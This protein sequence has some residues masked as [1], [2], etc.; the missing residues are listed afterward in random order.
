MALRA[1]RRVPL[2]VAIAALTLMLGFASMNAAPASAQ[3]GVGTPPTLP[4]GQCNQVVA[5]TAA[6]ATTAGTLIIG[7]TT[8]MIA[9]GAPISN[10]AAVVVGASI[11]FIP[12]SGNSAGQI[13]GGEVLANTM[14][15]FAVC[16][17]VTDYTSEAALTIGGIQFTLAGAASFT[18]G[19]PTVGQTQQITL[20]VNP[21]G[22]VTGGL[23]AASASCAA[24]STTLQG[25]YRTFQAPTATAQ[26]FF[27]FG[28]ATFYIAPGTTITATNSVPLA[29][30]QAVGHF[31]IGAISFH[32]AE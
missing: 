20:M 11:C 28:G 32:R 29:A 6:T 7:A 2:C 1:L 10:Q 3:T 24:G 15:A 8:Y 17:A 19:T 12:G 4:P 18:G 25:P 16:G 9:P 26:G 22:V 27:T 31:H 14:S 30:R 13:S 21:L 5:Y 23:V